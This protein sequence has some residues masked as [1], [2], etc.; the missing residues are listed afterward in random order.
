MSIKSH[1]KVVSKSSIKCLSFASGSS[2]NS[3]VQADASAHADGYPT[4]LSDPSDCSTDVPYLS[5]IVKQDLSSNWTF[6]KLE[7]RDD[8]YSVFGTYVSCSSN[9]LTVSLNCDDTYV[10]SGDAV[11]CATL[12]HIWAVKA[13]DNRTGYYTLSSSARKD[14]SKGVLSA[15]FNDTT[16]VLV[17]K[18]DGSGR[19]QW[20]LPGYPA[21][22]LTQLNDV[23]SKQAKPSGRKTRLL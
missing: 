11:D 5:S 7:N 12:S 4:W 10:T 21:E 8:V 20:K 14:C 9:Y 3:T 6:A 18:D 1:L 19:Q 15:G 16:L 17:E 23:T 2:F 13:V 22:D